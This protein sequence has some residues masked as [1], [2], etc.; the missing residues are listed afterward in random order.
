ME[1]EVTLGAMS[2]S[3]MYTVSGTYADPMKSYVRLKG[4]AE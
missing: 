3:D 1:T 4:Y 2:T